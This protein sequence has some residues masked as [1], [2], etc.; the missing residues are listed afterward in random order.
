MAPTCADYNGQI[1]TP[2]KIKA[3]LESLG[4]DTTDYT[5]EDASSDGI[6]VQFD[7]VN[8]IGFYN[9]NPMTG[10]CSNQAVTPRT[11]ICCCG[12]TACAVPSTSVCVGAKFFESVAARLTE[13]KDV[14]LVFEDVFDDD[15]LVSV[16]SEDRRELV[17][18]SFTEQDR[19]A[20]EL[21][22]E[23][24]FCV[25]DEGT[26]VENLVEAQF[27]EKGDVACGGAVV[28]EISTSYDHVY[29]LVN[30][31]MGVRTADGS[32]VSFY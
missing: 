24:F 1:D 21:T 19:I 20:F 8:K 31:D 30:S 27:I 6:E 5:Y 4:V 13:L 29:T 25:Q 16:K 9:G 28:S 23:H 22:P 12:D 14:P 32:W 17:K 11:Q 15:T 10:Y 26:G 3:L 18:I 2:A 7:A